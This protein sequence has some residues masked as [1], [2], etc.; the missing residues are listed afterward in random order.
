MLVRQQRLTLERWKE[1]RQNGQD[2]EK[3]QNDY[4]YSL[5]CRLYEITHLMICQ[6]NL[7][8]VLHQWN[9]VQR[10]DTCDDQRS[11]FDVAMEWLADARVEQIQPDVYICLKS[12]F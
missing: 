9:M 7:A 12:G 3:S 4:P 1:L 5:E 6:K 10:P 11:I 8:S 2:D